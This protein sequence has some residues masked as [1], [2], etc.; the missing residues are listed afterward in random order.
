VHYFLE[1]LNIKSFLFF[2]ERHLIRIAFF[3]KQLPSDAPNGVSC[4]VHRLANAL[5]SL[6]HNV[7]CFSFSPKP[8][9]AFYSHVKLEYKRKGAL[10]KLFATAIVF[11]KIAKI[12]F[13]ICHYH[14][15]DYLCNGAQNRVRTFYGSALYEALFARSMIR[16][17]RQFLFYGLEWVSCLKKG[18][19]VGISKTTR[20]ALPRIRYSISCGIPLDL[21]KP[22][23]I[24][25]QHPSILFIGDFNSRKRGKLLVDSFLN[26]IVK[27]QPTATLTIIGPDTCI[28]NNIICK[29]HLAEAALIAEYQ[30]AWVYC[31]PSSY[32]GFGVPVIEAMACNTAVIACKNKGIMEFCKNGETCLLCNEKDLPSTIIKLLKDVPLRETHSINALEFVQQY[33]SIT[34]AKQYIHAYQNIL[35]AKPPEL[36]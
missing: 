21:Y 3:S 7:T 17:I 33:D 12:D 5:V 34:I 32:E 6:G 26:H 18:T 29:S 10:Y 1:V 24:K 13:D 36:A 25:T 23:L 9:D 28:S 11:S 16:K 22:A 15:D 20:D 19:C 27:D 31:C 35:R 14:G 2:K 8:Q 4:Q 30:K